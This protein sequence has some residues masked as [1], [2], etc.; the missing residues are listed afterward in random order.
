MEIINTVSI[1]R[2][3]QHLFPMEFLNRHGK[4]KAPLPGMGGGSH[5]DGGGGGGGG[6]RGVEVAG[7]ITYFLGGIFFSLAFAGRTPLA[8]S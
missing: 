5:R 1:I 7:E 2:V 8:V 3:S 6:E 4:K